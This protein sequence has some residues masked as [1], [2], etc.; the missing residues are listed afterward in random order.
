[1]VL[2]IYQVD[3]FA[4]NVFKG[5]P[6]AV[7]PL[8]YWL[9]TEIM[10]QIAAE[11]NLSETAFYVPDR[12]NYHIRWFTP[13][14]EVDLCGHATLATAHVLFQHD[15]LLKRSIH[16][17]SRKGLLSVMKTDLGYQMD[18]PA[19]Q[20]LPVVDL[21]GMIESSIGVKPLEL[22]QGSDDYLAILGS[23]E[24]VI[25]CIPDYRRLSE[26]E[27]RGLIISATGKAV[28]FVSRGFFPRYG[29]DEDPVTGS[30][31]TLLTPYWSKKLGKKKLS[32]IQVSNRRG[33]LLCE[34]KHDRVLISGT[35]ITYLEGNIYV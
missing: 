33:H 1:M 19:D 11:N 20:P 13:M 2:K 25:S 4:S 27:T 9:E 14:K 26:I 30:A 22:F 3:A 17:Q 8:D 16:F 12:G 35:A 15:K 7:V 32:A 5:N 29:I 28:D 18:F 21:K 34:L 23:E 6:A 24:Q 10:Q 31:H